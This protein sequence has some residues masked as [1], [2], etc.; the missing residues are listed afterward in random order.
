VRRENGEVRR[1]NG[2]V[3]ACEKWKGEGRR[4]K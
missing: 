2:E 4:E 1:E 3:R